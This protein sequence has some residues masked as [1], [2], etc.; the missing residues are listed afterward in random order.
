M[1]DAND[2]V[3][4]IFAGVGGQGVL[5]VSAIVAQA[6]I[7]SGADVK[8]NEV[9][10][11]AQRGGSVLAQVRYGPKVY[12]PLVWEGTVDLLISLE[13]S[14]ALRY[15]HF[16]K[17]GALAVVS[18]QR[19]LPVTVSSG[20]ATYPA[21]VAERLARVFPRLVTLDAPGI[22]HSLGSA[23]A[24]NVVA[25]GAAAAS[26]PTLERHWI[27]AIAACVNEKYRELN[28]RAFE[29]GRAIGSG[30]GKSK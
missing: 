19:I 23:K 26:L 9:H 22:A 3:N 16:L 13:E 25:L 7:L 10:G 4:I 28:L 8:G 17:P 2:T 12:S 24:A 21:D 27:D 14:E 18:T 30:G 11:M 5:L 15:A 6:A 20:K 1:S 29:S